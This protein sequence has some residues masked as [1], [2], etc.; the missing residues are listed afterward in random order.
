MRPSHP[1]PNS[2]PWWRHGLVWFV[3]SG[4]AIVV[5]AGIA[6]AVIAIR[7]ADPLVETGRAAAPQERPAV[8]ARNH[9]ATPDPAR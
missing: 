8:T 7:G 6:T 4:P 9:A 5:V 3:I 1:A 2:P